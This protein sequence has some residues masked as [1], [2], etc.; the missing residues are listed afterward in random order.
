MVPTLTRT[1]TGWWSYTRYAVV[2]P[3]SNACTHRQQDI[4]TTARSLQKV[5]ADIEAVLPHA[6][7]LGYIMDSTAT[8]RKAMCQLRKKDPCIV[9]LPC[10]AHAL[11]L[12]VKHVDK[13]FSWVR[14]VFASC[15]AILER[16]INSEKVRSVLHDHQRA[17]YHKKLSIPAHA[18]TRFGNMVIVMHG[19]LK[20][21]TTLRQ[22]TASD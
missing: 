21:A 14:R 16:L 10:V 11:S 4:D 9:V 20:C 18:P 3:S 12:I 5:R 2:S 15:C 1:V 6:T 13:N 19:I 22:L 7:F 8:N 17:V